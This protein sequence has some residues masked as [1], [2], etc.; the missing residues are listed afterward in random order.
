MFRRGPARAAC[1]PG[2]RRLHQG[3]A[4]QSRRVCMRETDWPPKFRRGMVRSVR[5]Q[6][7]THHL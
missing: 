6:R 4:P 7:R 3:A 5:C 1:D 2:I